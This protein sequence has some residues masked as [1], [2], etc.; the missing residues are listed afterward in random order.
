MSVPVAAA[1]GPTSRRHSVITQTLQRRAE[2]LA[3]IE[4]R[5]ICDQLRL[6]AGNSPDIPAYSDQVPGD[7]AAGGGGWQTLTWGQTRQR[8]LELAA[9]F[10]ALGLTPR[11]RVALMLP[12]RSEHVLADFGAVHAGGLGVTCYATLAPEQIAFVAGD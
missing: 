6:T 1:P 4:G 5:T 9:G 10:A 3:A 12:N 7:A 2:I 11:E 8:V